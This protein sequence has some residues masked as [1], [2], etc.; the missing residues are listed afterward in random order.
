MARY[1]QIA[2]RA[3]HLIRAYTINDVVDEQLAQQPNPHA[4]LPAFGQVMRSLEPYLSELIIARAERDAAR[5]LVATNL[6]RLR[7]GQL[8][9]STA[10]ID[11]DLLGTPPLDPYTGETLRLRIED[12]QVIVYSAGLDREYDTGRGQAPARF[13]PLDEFK[14]LP[15]DQLNAWDGDWVF[16]ANN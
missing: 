13:V 8:P 15:R 5:L 16:N 9:A 4:L 6:H 10:D 3:P 11:A 14:K 12:G 2:A 1:Q 7:H